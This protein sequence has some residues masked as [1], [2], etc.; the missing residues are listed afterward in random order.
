M[1]HIYNTWIKFGEFLGKISSTIIL[2]FL[3]FFLFT[4]IAIF[5]KLIGKD[6]LNKKI[7][8]NK[9]SYW[10]SREMQPTSMKYQF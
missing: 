6:L 2:F 4:P 5:L 9:T 3:F 1:K 7:D 8:K 10:L